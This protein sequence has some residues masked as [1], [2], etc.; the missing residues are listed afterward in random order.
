MKDLL[1]YNTENFFCEVEDSAGNIVAVEG[2][3]NLERDYYGT[4]VVHLE[5]YP[6]SKELVESVEDWVYRNLLSQDF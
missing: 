5:F 4:Y 1:R 3:V 6:Y 2:Y